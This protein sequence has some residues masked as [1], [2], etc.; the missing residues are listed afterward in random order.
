MQGTD[1][2]KA[3][4]GKTLIF[5][6]GPSMFGRVEFGCVRGKPLHPQTFAMATKE[7]S[8]FCGAM[9]PSSIPQ[10]QQGAVQVLKEPSKE[11]ENLRVS[12]RFVGEESNEQSQTPAKGR[13][14]NDRNRRD[15]LVEAAHVSQER[16]EASRAPSPSDHRQKQEAAFVEE[17]QVSPTS[18]DFFL[19]EASRARSNG[20]WLLRRARRRALRAAGETNPKNEGVWGYIGGCSSPGIESARVLRRAGWSRGR[21]RSRTLARPLRAPERVSVSAEGRVWK[22][23][24]ERAWPEGHLLREHETERSSD[25]RSSRWPEGFEPPRRRRIPSPRAGRPEV[26]AFRVLAE[27]LPASRFIESVPRDSVICL[28]QCDLQ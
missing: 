15:L 6:V 2:R 4:V 11:K 10:H 21:S 8:H 14:R 23:P 28:F 25:R 19:Y 12:D 26:D 5:Q 22:K 17:N 3:E 13:D 1:S 24:L 27:F 9:G 18:V 16:G 7:V 20:E